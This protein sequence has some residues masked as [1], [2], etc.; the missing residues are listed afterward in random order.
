LLEGSDRFESIALHSLASSNTERAQKIR[1]ALP[2][3]YP[4]SRSQESLP[5]LPD[6]LPGVSPLLPSES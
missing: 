3:E 4:R 5:M 1:K 6:P 2:T